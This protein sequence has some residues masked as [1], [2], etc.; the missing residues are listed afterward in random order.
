MA[1]IIELR[2]T[3]SSSKQAWSIDKNGKLK[4]LL[5]NAAQDGKANKELIKAIAQTLKIPQQDVEIISGLT[6][7]TKRIKIHTAITLE[8]F[9]QAC[10]LETQIQLW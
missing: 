3:P 2:V 1:L 10:G 6:C 7:R 5:K 8:Q 4:L 9:L